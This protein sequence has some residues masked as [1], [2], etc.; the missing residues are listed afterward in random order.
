M[1]KKNNCKSYN[2]IIIIPEKYAF[3]KECIN[4]TFKNIV[5]INNSTNK[6]KIIEIINNFNIKKMYLIGNHDLYN[7]IITRINKKTQI[8]WIYDHSFSSLSD[9]NIRNFLNNLMEYVDRE[10]VN[11]IGCIDKETYKVFT[12]AGYNCEYIKLKYN[13]KTK[14]FT[15][16]NTIGILSNDKDSNNNY[17]NQ[18]AS[19]SFLNYDYCK[20]Y[21]PTNVTKKFLKIFNIKTK[22]VDSVEELI[23]DNAVNLYINFT[24]TNFDLIYKSFNYGVPCLLGNSDIFDNDKYLKEHLILNSDDD[25]NEITKKISF[26]KDNKKEI[27]KNYYIWYSKT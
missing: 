15:N 10:I 24:N 3:N 20:I 25:I 26:I 2:N 16:T 1:E 4:N 17:Y 11:L 23:K 7:Y 6:T 9:R 5:Y 8:C 13:N 14:K 12:N 19:L 27:L 18:L 22:I 21:N